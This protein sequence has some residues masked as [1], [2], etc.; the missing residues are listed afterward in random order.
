MKAVFCK[1][2]SDVNSFRI[3]ETKK[4]RCGAREVLV[5]LSH[6]SVSAGDGR[7]FA[8]DMPAMFKIPMRIM[9]GITKPR[10]PFGM[11]FSGTIEHTGRDVYAFE[12]GDAVFGSTEMSMGCLAEYITIKAS[13]LIAKMPAN[14]SFEGAA[15]LYFGANTALDF[16]QK[17]NIGK[18]KKVLIYG[19]S[20]AV[21]AAAVQICRYH[22][23]HVTGICGPDN[24]DLVKSLGPD[25][26]IDYTSQELAGLN[27][28][29]DIFFDTVGKADIEK[30]FS[31]IH[32][33]G[34]YISANHLE[35]GRVKAGKKCAKKNN[36]RIVAGI[37][38]TKKENLAELQK[39]FAKGAIDPYIDSVFPLEKVGEAFKRV[40]SGHKRGN[41]VVTIG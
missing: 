35:S 18:D 41:V 7:M 34:C 6:T 5:K 1:R 3:E 28:K 8:L 13:G 24:M 19:A 22:Q 9:L 26:V 16:L 25:T 4:P 14:K 23:A 20:G 30:S 32:A 21:G 33:T 29:Y 11:G 36:V 17:A 10:K 39:F 27:Q 12:K 40:R 15:A 37:S 31:L 38:A 2:Y